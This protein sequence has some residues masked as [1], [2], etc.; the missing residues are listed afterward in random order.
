M[1]S[2]MNCL[3]LEPGRAARANQVHT[4]SWD[5][6]PLSTSPVTAFRAP[7]LLAIL[8]FSNTRHTF[9]VK[10]CRREWKR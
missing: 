2:F 9:Q 3:G 4:P 1:Y 10:Y 5:Q 8:H 7:L 6:P